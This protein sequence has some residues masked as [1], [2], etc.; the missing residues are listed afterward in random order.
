M[1]PDWLGLIGHLEDFEFFSWLLRRK[2][3]VIYRW[4][5]EKISSVTKIILAALWTIDS[6]EWG[7]DAKQVQLS[8]KT[9]WQLWLEWWYCWWREVELFPWWLGSWVNKFGGTSMKM[10]WHWKCEMGLLQLGL[11]FGTW[12]NG[13][14]TMEWSSKEAQVSLSL[15]VCV[16]IV[17]TQVRHTAGWIMSSLSPESL[18]VWMIIIRG[19]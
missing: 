18:R 8:T 13:A 15:E 11:F 5:I 17:D 19:L 7:K 6:R 14:K 9:W 12:E 16:R 1:G 10:E 2:L 3:K 4:D